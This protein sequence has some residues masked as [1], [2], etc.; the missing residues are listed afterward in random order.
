MFYY[1]TRQKIQQMNQAD[2]KSLVSLN[3]FTSVQKYFINPWRE[4]N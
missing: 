4:I 2:P 3:L 1:R